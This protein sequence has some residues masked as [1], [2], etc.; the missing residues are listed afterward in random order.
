MRTFI[1]AAVLAVGILTAAGPTAAQSRGHVAAAED[2]LV[3]MDAGRMYERS[4]EQM[5][6]AQIAADP[7]LAAYAPV[8]RQFFRDFVSWEVVRPEHMR[9]HMERFSEAE[10]RAL[11]AFY[12]TPLG[13]KVAEESPGI[14]TELGM[15]GQRL[16]EENQAELLR[17][18][19][20][21]MTT[22]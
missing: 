19:M 20:E 8:M 2:L 16:V 21:S 7:D 10:L 9:V 22:E 1:A 13:R 4:L 17:R 3:A 12:R 6:S 18:I 15:V 14:A 11:A 5:L